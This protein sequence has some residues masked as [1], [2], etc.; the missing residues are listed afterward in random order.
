M[1]VVTKDVDNTMSLDIVN[2][3]GTRIACLKV[4]DEGLVELTTFVGQ[5]IEVGIEGIGT[6][7]TRVY[8]QDRRVV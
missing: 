5:E 2:S 6:E 1:I 3:A 4:Y 8:R 7:D